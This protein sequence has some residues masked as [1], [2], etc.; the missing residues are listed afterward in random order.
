[1]V[2]QKTRAPSNICVQKE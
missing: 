1:M 2:Q